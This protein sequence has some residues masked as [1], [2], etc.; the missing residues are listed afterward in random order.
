MKSYCAQMTVIVL[1]ALLAVA[2]SADQP[3]VTGVFGLTTI[4]AGAA[5]AVW[6]PL[7]SGESVGGVMWYNN[8]GSKVFPELLAVAG[9]PDYP[10]VLNEAVVIGQDVSGP[11]LDWAEYSFESAYASATS[12]LFLVFRLPADGAFVEDGDGAGLGYELGDGEIRCWIATGEGQWGMLSPDYQ[13]SVVPVMNEDKS[14]D[15][16]VLKLSEQNG[17]MEETQETPIASYSGLRIAPNPFNPRAA[18][19][20]FLPS[21]QRVNLAIY[22]IRGRKVLDLLSGLLT[23]GEHTVI[24]DGRDD[25]GRDVASGVYFGRLS[26]GT[27]GVTGRMVLIR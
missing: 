1:V 2:A 15:V 8:D 9:E 6:V 18:I 14:G 16:V 5:L 12:G 24:W 19:S 26:A 3:E 20:F 13:M 10:T 4:Q 25:Q 7:E 22:D 21:N 17:E 27:L 23:E 11:T